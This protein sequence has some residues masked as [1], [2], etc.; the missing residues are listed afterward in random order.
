MKKGKRKGRSDEGGQ[1]KKQKVASGSK[2][3]SE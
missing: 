3:T 1:K 2:G